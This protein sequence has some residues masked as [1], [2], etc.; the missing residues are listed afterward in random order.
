M[1]ARERKIHVK[2]I[3]I[4]L[5]MPLLT[6]RLRLEPPKL[7]DGKAI[8]DAV[9][10]NIENIAKWMPWASPPP[11]VDESE[12]YARVA[13]AEFI[14]RK[15]LAILIWDQQTGEL[16]GS[17]GFH[18]INWEVPSFEIGYWIRGNAIGQGFI[19][20]TVNALTRYAFQT[21]GARRVAIHCDKDNHKSRAVPEKLGFDLEGVLRNNALKVDSRTPRDTLVFSRVDLVGLPPLEVHW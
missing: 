19:M 7:G 11:G 6:P 15:I 12:E 14:Q 5:P 20:E 16:L 13:M 1:K 17:S 18:N 2:P 8:N 10:S 21:L 4:D 9:L 3:L